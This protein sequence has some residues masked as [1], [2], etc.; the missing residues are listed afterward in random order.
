MY[1]I[2]GVPCI[3]HLALSAL[4]VQLCSHRLHLGAVEVA[5]A[6]AVAR[7]GARICPCWARVSAALC[8]GGGS[9]G[10]EAGAQLLLQLRHLPL[11]AALHT[12]NRVKIA[13]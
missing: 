10:K 9:C 8:L 13:T 4:G 7:I 3:G 6:V 12:Q 2:Q 5:V 1:L 11:M